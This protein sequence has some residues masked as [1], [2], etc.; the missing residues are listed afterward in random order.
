MSSVSGIRMPGLA[1]GMDTDTMVKDMLAAEQEKIDDIKGDKQILQWQ[2]EIYRDI[3]GDVKSFSD[4]YLSMASKDS[5]LN[6]NNW[7]TLEINSSNSNVI[8]AVGTSG[9]SNIDYTF[10]VEKL[11]SGATM[12]TNQAA[13]GQKLTK[14]STLES[15][16]A[17]FGN[18]DKI[19]FKIK[20]SG[21]KEDELKTITLTKD[22]TIES[23]VKKINDASDGKF[24]ATFSEMTGEFKLESTQTGENSSLQIVNTDGSQSNALE[25]LDGSGKRPNQFSIEQKGENS[26]I[27]VKTNDGQTINLS[28]ESN[29]FSI[30]GINYTVNS[31][32]ESKVTSKQNFDKVTE[33]MKNF[34]DDYNKL[35]DDIYKKILEKKNKD[36][37]P[38]TEKQKKD[39]SEEEIKKWEENAKKGILKNDPDLKRF[40]DDMQ[41]AIFGDNM[42]FMMSIGI[43]GHEDY[44]KRGQLSFDEEKFKKALEENGQELYKKMAGSSDSI[45]EGVNSTIKK[46]IGSSSS[47]FAKKAGIESTASVAENYYSDEIKKKE[48]LISNLVNKMNRKE[49]ALY[50]KFALMEKTMSK[51]NAQMAQFFQ[52]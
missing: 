10:K 36:Y 49:T 48:E 13:N 35:M 46:Y 3:I 37:K 26:K 16:G 1:T 31:V 5:I 22:D 29:S 11:A 39:M 40:M 12:K 28:K 4:K 2:Q 17:N 41:K 6:S 18:E 14:T 23:M 27:E 7:N 33:N 50:K 30:D 25:F 51:L 32:G 47:I 38:L 34:V 8:S 44:N 45:L 24:K 9:A 52:A 42:E 19:E 43:S 21:V 15:L 20:T